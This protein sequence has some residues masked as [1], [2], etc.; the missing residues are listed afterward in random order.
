MLHYSVPCNVVVSPSF[1]NVFDGQWAHKHDMD[2]KPC[3][4]WLNGDSL[5]TT[6][7]Q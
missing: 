5:F 7:P 4:Y 6:F 2:M 1:T 3:V